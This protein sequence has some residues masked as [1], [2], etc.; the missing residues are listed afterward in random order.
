M[1]YKCNHC[2]TVT[3]NKGGSAK[4]VGM[5]CFAYFAMERKKD[6]V[7]YCYECAKEI[8]QELMDEL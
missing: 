4:E 7:Y 2:G 5:I 6:I 3:E 8:A 1:K